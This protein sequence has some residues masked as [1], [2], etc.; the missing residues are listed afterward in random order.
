[1]L[2]AGAMREFSV[3]K[4]STCSRPAASEVRSNQRGHNETQ[5]LKRAKLRRATSA[6]KQLNELLTPA[7]ALPRV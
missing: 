4:F 2:F 3:Y 1:M 6:S 7:E 5:G